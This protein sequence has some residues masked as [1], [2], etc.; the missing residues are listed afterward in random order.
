VSKDSAPSQAA[1]QTPQ[2]TVNAP[3]LASA[4]P[5]TTVVNGASTEAALN[6]AAQPQKVYVL[7]SDIEAADNATQV[8]VAEASF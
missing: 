2:A 6:R 5:T 1:P 8:Q 3:A 7:Q 4:V